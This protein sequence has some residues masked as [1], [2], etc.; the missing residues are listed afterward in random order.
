MKKPIKPWHWFRIGIG[1][2]P[3]NALILPSKTP[4][5]TKLILPKNIFLLLRPKYTR[6]KNNKYIIISIERV[7]ADAL[8]ERIFA[9]NH[10][11]CIREIFN[12]NSRILFFISC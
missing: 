11:Y 8:N 6:I 12:K 1:G 3:H 10:P 4:I 7:H 5:Q 2:L 9:V